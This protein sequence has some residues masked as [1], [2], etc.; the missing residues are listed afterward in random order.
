MLVRYNNKEVSV[1]DTK[2]TAMDKIRYYIDNHKDA[3]YILIQDKFIN[4]IEIGRHIV[5][6]YMA[7]SESMF[8]IRDYK[9]PDIEIISVYLG[10]KCYL[11]HWVDITLMNRLINRKYGKVDKDTTITVNNKEINRYIKPIRTN[12]SLNVTY[13]GKLQTIKIIE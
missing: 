9:I 11:D 3:K 5:S 2:R 4:L 6:V 8:L 12:N 10:L 1:I 13:K 7:T